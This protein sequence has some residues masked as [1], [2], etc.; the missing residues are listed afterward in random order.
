M[1]ILVVNGPNLNLLGV[2]EPE[3]YGTGTYADLVAFVERLRYQ[4]LFRHILSSSCMYLYCQRKLMYIRQTQ[5]LL[6]HEYCSMVF[7]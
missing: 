4:H 1:R 3:I 2:R 6:L 5:S 7:F